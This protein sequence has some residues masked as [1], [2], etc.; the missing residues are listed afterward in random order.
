[1]N[2]ILTVSELAQRLKLTDDTI[3]QMVAAG[4]VPYFRVGQKAGAIRFRWDDIEK[5]IEKQGEK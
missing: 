2:D 1:M 5:W 3:Y 4:K